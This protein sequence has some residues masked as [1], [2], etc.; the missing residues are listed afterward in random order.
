MARMPLARYA[1]ERGVDQ[2]AIRHAWKMGLVERAADGT[3]NED[4]ADATWLPQHQ[5]RSA[6]QAGN[7]IRDSRML[8]AKYEALVAKT[9][10]A[11]HKLNEL[12][13]S[14]VDRAEVKVQARAELD[15]VMASLRTLPADSLVEELGLGPDFARRLM[16]EFVA[17]MLDDLGDVYAGLDLGKL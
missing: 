14:V 17:M 11:R 6:Q 10:L 7:V 2:S 13:A 16:D 3:V 1:R 15:L 8:Q 4:Q 5:A 9:E 12:E